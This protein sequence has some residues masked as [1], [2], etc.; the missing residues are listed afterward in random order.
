MRPPSDAMLLH[1]SRCGSGAKPGHCKE[2]RGER[3]EEDGW[4][5]GLPPPGRLAE[6]LYF[7]AG[8]RPAFGIDAASRLDR[9]VVVQNRFRG[10][11][12]KGLRRRGLFAEQET[13][14]PGEGH[15]EPPGAGVEGRT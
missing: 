10:C 14:Q 13:V 2:G 1:Q 8:T 9:V 4:G 7:R 3:E 11:G 15:V 12:A 5:G 6:A